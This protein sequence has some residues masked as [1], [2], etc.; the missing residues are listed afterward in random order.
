M[1]PS[2]DRRR[3]LQ[4]LAIAA[5]AL[6][7]DPERLLWIPGRKTIFI[8][9]AVLPPDFELDN[10]KQEFMRQVF[11]VGVESV[12]PVFIPGLPWPCG[13]IRSDFT[14]SHPPH[15]TTRSRR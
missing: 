6:T 10:M 3:F 11:G 1:L 7:V 8:P 5:S 4:Q 15:E 9:A 13:F 2:V 14:S 12:R